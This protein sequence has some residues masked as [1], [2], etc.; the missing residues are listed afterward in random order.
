M[1]WN[2]GWFARRWTL[3]CSAFAG[4]ASLESFL[5]FLPLFL[6]KNGLN[7]FA[8]AVEFTSGPG[9]ELIGDSLHAFLRRRKWMIQSSWGLLAEPAGIRTFKV[10]SGCGSGSPGIQALFR[11]FNGV[12]RKNRDCRLCQLWGVHLQDRE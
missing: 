7:R 8:G 5:E 12:T 11:D 10:A 6:R 4:L 9:Q 2:E 3:S 1:R